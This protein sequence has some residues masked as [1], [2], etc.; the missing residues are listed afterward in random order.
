MK[1]LTILEAAR[2]L[3][4][5]KN[6][7]KYQVAKM[8]VDL[9]YKDESGKTY[10]KPAGIKHLRAVM[11]QKPTHNNHETTTQETTQQPENNR[12]T[13]TQENALLLTIETL[14]EQL[15]AKDKQLS[16]K[17]K[18]IENL[19]TALINEQHSAQQAH[20]LHAGTMQA[21]R[22]ELRSGETAPVR[23][24]WQFWKKRNE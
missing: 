13:T 6:A 7:V 19:T 2:E 14:R 9:V 18:Q 22:L 21:G 20:A 15:L 23:K 11:G 1:D 24:G 17:D 5:T 3:G 12:T 10:I 4:Y 16:E 8:P